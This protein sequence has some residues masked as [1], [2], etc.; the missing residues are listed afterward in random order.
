MCAFPS[1]YPLF[2]P[3]MAPKPPLAVKIEVLLNDKDK[4]FY[5][6]DTVRGKI[7]IT[8]NQNYSLKNLRLAWTGRIHVQP[9]K[10]NKEVQKYFNECWKLGPKITKA[11]SK[12]PYGSSQIS[13]YKGELI[14]VTDQDA[15]PKVEL[16]KNKPF[17]F[18]FEVHVPNDRPLPSSTIENTNYKIIYLLEAFIARPETHGEENPAFFGQRTVPVLEP[19]YTRTEEMMRPQR[20]EQVFTVVPSNDA[21]EYKAAVRVTLPCRG[22]QTGVAIPIS[23]SIW[24]N[25]EFSRKQGISISLFRVNQLVAN[26]R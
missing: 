14:S 4:K 6:G 12:T 19:I 3:P 1:F 20:A 10:D 9:L 16:S 7:F 23:I 21:V 11:P 13:F 15:E 26:G 8:S 18:A 5:P 2:N 22:C 17:A 24:N 25:V